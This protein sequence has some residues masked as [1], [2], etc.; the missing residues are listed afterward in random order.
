[1]KISSQMIFMVSP[2]WI[3]L[4]LSFIFYLI[5]YQAI[6]FF[7]GLVIVCFLFFLTFWRDFLSF[8]FSG[9]LVGLKS[10]K[11]IF[12]FSLII[13][14]GFTELVWAISFLPFSFF[15]LGGI[16]AVIFGVVLDIYKE[17]FKKFVNDDE[18]GIRIKKILIR[19]LIAG[20]VLITIFIF[21][22]KWLPPKAS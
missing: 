12:I 2:V 5:L 15:I 22:S 14:F 3:L 17:Y 8:R 16:M 11:Q 20:I 7:S 1:M 9:E 18:A 10:K 6:S 4:T 13:A 19:D 21:I